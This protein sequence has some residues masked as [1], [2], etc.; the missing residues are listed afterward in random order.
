MSDVSKIENIALIL[1][2]LKRPTLFSIQ[3]VEDFYIFFNGYIAAKDDLIVADFLNNFSDFEK[4]KYSE[5]DL[6][7]YDCHKIIR[8]HSAN[9][10]HSLELLNLW[11]S[12]FI[13]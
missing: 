12:E 8:L 4:D 2:S 13:S 1:Y 7:N 6:K 10:S 3:K 9:D 11:V 5:H